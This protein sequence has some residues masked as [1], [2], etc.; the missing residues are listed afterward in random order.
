LIWVKEL[1]ISVSLVHLPGQNMEYVDEKKL[2][3]G[4]AESSRHGH[5]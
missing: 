3:V 5:Q 2:F 1:H 4:S